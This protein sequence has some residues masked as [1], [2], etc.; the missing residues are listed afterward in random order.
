MVPEALPTPT[1]PRKLVRAAARA[2]DLAAFLAAQEQRHPFYNAVRTALAAERAGPRRARREQQLR[3]DLEHTRALPRTGRH[4]VVDLGS[5]QLW[6]FDGQQLAGTMKVIVGAPDTRTPTMV[7][8]VEEAVARPYWNVPEDLAQTRI[9]PRVLRHGTVHLQ[10]Q[11][12]KLLS[13]WT[14][15]AVELAPDAVDWKAAAARRVSVRVRQEPGPWNMMGEMKFLI[16]NDLGIYLHDTPER[17]LFRRKDRRLSAG[18]IRVED[19]RR[20]ADWLFEGDPPPGQGAPE[21]VHPL[22][23]AVPIHV[24][25]FATAPAGPA[26]AVPATAP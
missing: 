2:D 19:W 24:L 11:H 8:L 4:I 6:M 23:H 7:S 25:R 12:L 17:D 1:D 26:R 9:A 18:C 14:D 3:A 10:Q 5:Q 13:D 16:R 22:P 21:Q 20:L 15:Q